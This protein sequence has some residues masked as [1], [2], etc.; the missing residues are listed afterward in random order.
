[1]INTTKFPTVTLEP[2]LF[3]EQPSGDDEYDDDDEVENDSHIFPTPEDRTR[4]MKIFTDLGVT[5]AEIIFSGSGDDGGIEDTKLSDAVGN[6]M[7]F[8]PKP[9][10]GWEIKRSE[11]GV[12]PATSTFEQKSMSVQDLLSTVFYAAIEETGLDW[13]N[14]EGGFGTLVIDFRN[15]R[16]HLNVSINQT[17]S[18]DYSH[19]Y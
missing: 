2:N 17:S 14:D 15:T 12:T 18:I 10:M 1:M 9:V 3:I 4:F 13:Y 19:T 6:V 11:Y 16:I 8:P 5:S 7:P